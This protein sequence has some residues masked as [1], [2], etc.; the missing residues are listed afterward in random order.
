MSHDLIFA[1][2]KLP[3]DRW[4]PDH[5]TLLGLK[6][7]E[8]DGAVIEQGAHERHEM[9]RGYQLAHP[10]EVTEA[11][12]RVAQAFDCLTNPTTKQAY[13]AVLFPDRVAP[14]A[15]PVP[16]PAPPLVELAPIAPPAVA[17]EPLPLVPVPASTSDPLAW[18]YG[19]WS[20]PAAETVEAADTAEAAPRDVPGPAAFPPL[21]ELTDPVLEIAAH[22]L[23]ARRGLGTK[24]AL[25]FRISRTR[26]LLRAWMLLGSTIGDATRPLTSK[27]DAIELGRQL[28]VV[29]Q[30]L[31]D[32]PPLLGQA[33]QPGAYVVT[34]ARQQMI[35]QTFLSL[36]PSQRERLARDWLSALELLAAH[37]RFLRDELWAMRRHGWLWRGYRVVRGLVTDHPVLWLVLGA[38]LA[39][40]LVTP[41]PGTLKMAQAVA[42]VIALAGHVLYRTFF[43]RRAW[44][45][46]TRDRAS[47]GL[48]A[49]KQTP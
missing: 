13:D 34:L 16:P 44:L 32:F 5:Y 35:V 31:Q 43:T 29:R 7:G 45:H 23:P 22:S 41:L 14:V 39:I 24:R 1:W 36:L 33:G 4:P 3:A 17:V 19:P 46:R 15:T 47:P 6:P 27:T 26:Q 11:L 25:Y 30:L 21:P 2:L 28:T 42:V 38:L 48:R 37:R 12:N 49:S 20:Q 18:L 40:N 8:S 9:L 10:E